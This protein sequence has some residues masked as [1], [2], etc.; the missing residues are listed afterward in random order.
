MLRE[1]L[2]RQVER[3]LSSLSPRERDVL[4]LRFSIGD[5]EAHTLDEVGARFDLTRERIRQIEA[6]AL[7]KLRLAPRGRPLGAFTEN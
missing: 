3:A 7:R 4:R 1:D 6:V 5:A 2:A